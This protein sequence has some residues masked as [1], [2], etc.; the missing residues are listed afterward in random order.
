MRSR[1]RS[2]ALTLSA[3][4]VSEF[5]EKLFDEVVDTNVKGVWPGMKYEIPELLK[6]GGGAIVNITSG[7]DETTAGGVA[8]YVAS[9]HAIMGLSA[10]PASSSHRPHCRARRSRAGSPLHVRP[11]GRIYV[12]GI[13]Q[14]SL[15]HMP[16]VKFA[17]YS[18]CVDPKLPLDRQTALDTPGGSH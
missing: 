3:A 14:G 8:F 11:N 6:N 7:F 15:L 4:P 17:T 18:H 12:W 1:R 13:G 5:T 2:I 16:H 10:L 9:K